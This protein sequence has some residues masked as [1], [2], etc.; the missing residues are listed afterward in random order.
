VT[1]VVPPQ[2]ASAGAAG[3]KTAIR[4]STAI[5]AS[6]AAERGKRPA[7]DLSMAGRGRPV[8]NEGKSSGFVIVLLSQKGTAD[9]QDR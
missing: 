1:T 8:V 7:G 9:Y 6:S 3:R 5:R 4:P 2:A